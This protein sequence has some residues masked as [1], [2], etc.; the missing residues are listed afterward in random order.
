MLSRGATCRRLPELGGRAAT[1]SEPRGGMKIQL[2]SVPGSW[3]VTSKSLQFSMTGVALLF[4]VALG[5]TSDFK[6][7]RMG[8]GR[9]RKTNPVVAGLRH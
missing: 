5:T 3:E 4:E 2:A 6:E 8:A 9:A 7:L 1:S